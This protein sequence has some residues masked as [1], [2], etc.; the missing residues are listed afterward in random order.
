MEEK[1][2]T[3]KEVAQAVGRDRSITLK[4]IKKHDIPIVMIKTPDTNGQ[5]TVALT[6]DAYKQFLDLSGV[7]G[8]TSKKKY[9]ASAN[10]KGVFYLINPI[11]AHSK[12]RIKFGYTFSIDERVKE[13]K[14]ICPDMEIVKTW[15]IKKYQEKTIIDMAITKSDKRIGTEIYEI[16]DVNETIARIDVLAKMI[17]E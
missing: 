17:N 10:E 12:T 4:N 2:Y 15:P 9:V 1:L 7:Y 14:T 6:E 13:Y 16:A 11:P 3:I 8:V 5:K